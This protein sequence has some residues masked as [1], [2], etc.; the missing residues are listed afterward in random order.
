[1]SEIRQ[2]LKY[3]KDH[4]WVKNTSTTN[5]DTN[6]A[7]NIATN[8]VRVGIT[9]F[10]Q[11]SLGDVTFIQLP[12]VGSTF[13]S[14]EIFGTVESVKAVSDLFMPLSGK[15][16]ARNEALINDP[17]P[18]NTSPFDEAWMIEI[19]ITDSAEQNSLLNAEAY[20]QHAQ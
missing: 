16:V 8:I 3:T 11:A 18:V 4:E 1:M 13:R 9:D 10:A 2:D 15:I 12:E 14:G 7:T 6:V 5:T 20:A 19:E 17:A